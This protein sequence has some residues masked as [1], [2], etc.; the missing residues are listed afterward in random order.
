MPRTQLIDAKTG[1][2]LEDLGWYETVSQARSACSE[3]A[4]RL[5]FWARS[6]DDLWVAEEEDEVYRVEMDLPEGSPTA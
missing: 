3:H 1:E 5:L 2:L 6:P 4:G